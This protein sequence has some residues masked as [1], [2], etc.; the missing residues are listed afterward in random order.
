MNLQETMELIHAIGWKGSRL[1]LERINELM[2]RLGNPQDEL[3]FIHVA[4]TN[5]KGSVCAMIAS[6]LT[7]SGYTVGLFTSPHLR[8]FNER[9]K[10][11]G[12]DISD[13]ELTALAEEISPHVERMAEKPTEFE[14][15]TAMALLYYQRKHCDPVVLEVG[16]GGRLDSTNVIP[17]PEAAVITSIGLDHTEVL[18]GTLEEIA[19]EKA[20]IIKE[21][22]LCGAVRAVR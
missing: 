20:G 4:G 12:T 16:L 5:G 3:R 11:N 21:K 10:I 6:V 13:E 9:I 7:E 18:G 15:T 2:N 8:R 14:L 22:K 19:R 1:G 17:S